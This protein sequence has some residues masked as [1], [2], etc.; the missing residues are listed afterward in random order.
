MEDRLRAL[1]AEFGL[2]QSPSPTKFQQGES[3]KRPSEKEGQPSD[4]IR[5]PRMWVDFPRWKGD[6]KGCA[7]RT[8]LPLL[9][10]TGGFYGGHHCHPPRRRCNSMTIMLK[11]FPNDDH[12]STAHDRKKIESLQRQYRHGICDTKTYWRE[13]KILKDQEE[14]I[15]T[16]TIYRILTVTMPSTLVLTLHDRGNVFAIGADISGIGIGT[17][18][19]Q[20]GRLLIYTEALPTFHMMLLIYKGILIATEF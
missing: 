14:G 15:H 11:V 16:S 4:M 10:N 13:I 3:S 1:F 18:L 8:L 6:P 7:R 12:R 5:P 19:M 2:G 9:P 17:I 20:D